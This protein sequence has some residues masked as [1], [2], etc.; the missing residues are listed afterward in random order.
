MNMNIRNIIPKHSKST[1]KARLKI[2][3][4]VI[5][6]VL[7][8][9]LLIG[10]ELIT[11]ILYNEKS[12][13]EIEKEYLSP[14]TQANLTKIIS[15]E[16]GI[17][18]KNENIQTSWYNNAYKYI[19][20]KGITS[21]KEEDA[22]K[23]ISKED[24]K[25]TLN[26]V[27]TV[28]DD[29]LLAEELEEKIDN[30]MDVEIDDDKDYISI[31]EVIEIYMSIN[32]NS[33]INYETL[34][35]FETPATNKQKAWQ[36]LTSKGEY[37]FEG[38]IIDPLINKTIKV[39]VKD[40][41]ILGVV[42][43]KR[44]ETVLDNCIVK[45][46]KKGKLKI[47]VNEIEA[48][49]STP[50][51]EGINDEN[52][53]EIKLNEKGRLVINKEGFVSYTSNEELKKNGEDINSI[54]NQQVEDNSEEEFIDFL[55]ST[56]DVRVVITN[57]NKDYSHSNVKLISTDDYNIVYA[58]ETTTLEALE[59]WNANEFEW[60]EKVNKI[61]LIPINEETGQIKLLTVEKSQGFP[62]YRGTIEVKKVGNGYEIVNEVGIEEYVANV[63]PSEMPISYGLEALKVQAVSARTYAVASIGGKKYEKYDADLD[64][65]TS[66]QVYNN[67]SP[68]NLA[69]QAASE[70]SGEVVV[71]NNKLLS[72]KFFA[73]SCGY[74]A[75]SG[76]VWASGDKFPS[77]TP[78]YLASA[79]QYSDEEIEFDMTK[80]EEAKKFLELMPEDIEGFD[81]ESAWFR[82]NVELSKQSLSDRVNNGTK[83][84]TSRYPHLVKVKEGEE[85]VGKTIDT[86]GIVEDIKVLERGEGGIIMTIEI[87]GD[88]N[89]IRV[90]T[91]YLIRYIISGGQDVGIS[92]VRMNGKE[93]GRMSLLPS[94]FFYPEISYDEHNKLE[95]VIIYGGGFG[96]G[97]GMSQDGVLGMIKEGHDYKEILE[98]YYEGVEVIK[99]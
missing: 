86:V 66:S 65:T 58:G 11:N 98:H 51:I 20:D 99:K 7:L 42:S 68:N 59:V 62:K 70:T 18:E 78:P 30:S 50:N 75:N 40:N 29:K 25:I 22:N 76:E 36:V 44:E 80:E 32:P 28:L 35:V 39:A 2:V 9:Y 67:Q 82:W 81:E 43:V 10:N 71:Y 77:Y 48:E 34:T 19:L 91:E 14:C 23:L 12:Y 38:L 47:E 56:K 15:Y 84:I 87:T 61:S 8:W 17:E 63:I 85:W 57:T 13:I 60:D 49:I 88:E 73:T 31:H 41:E 95:S 79:K 83:I 72:S 97:V 27:I 55:E 26:E 45:E 3:Y 90:D 37:G 96:H 64:D 24:L 94:A 16:L 92:V 93:S 1:R 69:Y 54:D 52:S 89:S 6:I 5:F 33:D 53:L 46:I 74:T 21:L 4:I